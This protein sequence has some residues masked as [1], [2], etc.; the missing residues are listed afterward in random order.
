MGG[1]K[2]AQPVYEVWTDELIQ[3]IN[4]TFEITGFLFCEPMDKPMM[5]LYLTTKNMQM[6]FSPHSVQIYVDMYSCPKKY[7]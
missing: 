2:K 3:D 1:E 6:P 7:P 4:Q 5:Q